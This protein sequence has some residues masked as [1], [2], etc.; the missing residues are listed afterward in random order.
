[1]LTSEPLKTYIAAVNEPYTLEVALEAR[2][3]YDALP[4]SLRSELSDEAKAK[5]DALTYFALT[6]NASQERPEFPRV[7]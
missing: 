5:I 1:M 7:Q 3:K 6:N 4:E 2:E